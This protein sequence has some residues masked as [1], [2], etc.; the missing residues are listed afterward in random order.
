[1]VRHLH[2]YQ[3]YRQEATS[4]N[5]GFNSA[6][7]MGGEWQFCVP[8][9]RENPQK[10]DTIR[11]STCWTTSIKN[12][13]IVMLDSQGLPE[14]LHKG[15]LSG[16]FDYSR[17]A[18]LY[19][20]TTQNRARDLAARDA[21]SPFRAPSQVFHLAVALPTWLTRGLTKMVINTAKQH[22]AKHLKRL[23]KFK[24]HTNFRKLG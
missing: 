3:V 11:F 10:P 16:G 24:R 22:E 23:L 21:K 6:E 9:V 18:C 5:A 14:Y 17:V 4:T 2:E 7:W 12:C 1:M 8:S 20:A 19:L 13:L 15:F